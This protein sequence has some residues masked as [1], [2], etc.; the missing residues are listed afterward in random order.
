MEEIVSVPCAYL[1]YS[2]LICGCSLY[3]SQPRLIKSLSS[4]VHGSYLQ[5]VM[6]MASISGLTKAV[7]E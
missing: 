6:E 4:L 7:M 3:F 1:Q 2:G 5:Y